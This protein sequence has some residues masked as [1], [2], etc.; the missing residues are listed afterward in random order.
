MNL[1]Q[2]Y[3]ELADSI[4]LFDKYE[5]KNA[6]KENNRRVVE[7]R[8]IASQIESSYPALKNDFCELLSYKNVRICVFVAHHILE[9]M[10]CDRTYRKKALQVIRLYAKTEKNVEGL[11]NKMW[12]KEWYK[13][14]PSDRFL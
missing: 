9:V 13:T 14:H 5:N 8:K 7:L 1:I 11:G 12:L 3:L 4:V 10:N 6:V 2:K